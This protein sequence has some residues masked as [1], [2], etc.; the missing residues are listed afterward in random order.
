[1]IRQ[2]RYE[3]THTNP[4]KTETTVRRQPKNAD[5]T[6]I[7]VKEKPKPNTFVFDLGFD[8]RH[9]CKSNRTADRQ[10]TLLCR[11][12]EK[13][14]D[15]QRKNLINV[16]KNCN[17]LQ[18]FVMNYNCNKSRLATDFYCCFYCQNML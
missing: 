7:F 6:R 1:M 10:A 15:N 18:F 17:M 5:K 4:E 9:S 3:H 8:W 12:K 2:K 13:N 14:Y 16:T 11:N